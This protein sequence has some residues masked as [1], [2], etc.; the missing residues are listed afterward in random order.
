MTRCHLS[1]TPKAQP[2]LH[3][4]LQRPQEAACLRGAGVRGRAA[5]RP[6]VQGRCVQPG[7]RTWPP[8][9]NPHHP[10]LP[11]TACSAHQ[12]PRAHPWRVRPSSCRVQRLGPSSCLSR[13]PPKSSRHP[14]GSACRE[15][16]EQD[17]PPP[18]P[19]PS[20]TASCL[21][22]PQDPRLRQCSG[23]G[24]APESLR[25]SG[26]PI[27][28]SSAVSSRCQQDTEATLR[29]SEEGF[30]KASFKKL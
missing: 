29:I 2:G 9:P 20:A 21:P 18:A 13:L 5:V 28:Y 10:V 27:M 11:P 6:G 22:W 8:C 19:P 7:C 16:P 14:V 30:I 24:Q 3:P 23:R 4:T 17:R 26:S 25:T 1:R 12:P 15:H